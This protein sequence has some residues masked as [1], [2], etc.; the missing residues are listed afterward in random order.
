M[1]RKVT[2]TQTGDLLS[3]YSRRN[4]GSP[5]LS[6]L[7]KSVLVLLICSISFSLTKSSIKSWSWFKSVLT[8]LLCLSTNWEFAFSSL[9][10]SISMNSITKTTTSY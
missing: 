7:V 10:Q 5:P 1:P 8:C 2:H 3:S 4:A 9:S 6:S